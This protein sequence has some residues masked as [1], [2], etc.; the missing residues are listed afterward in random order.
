MTPASNQN[1]VDPSGFLLPGDPFVPSN[2]EQRSYKS[3]TLYDATSFAGA[4][5]N[6]QES[7]CWVQGLLPQGYSLR[8]PTDFEE[9]FEPEELLSE[10]EF[11]M[12]AGTLER[13]LSLPL[14]ER[15][16]EAILA[17]IRECQSLFDHTLSLSQRLRMRLMAACR[18]ELRVLRKELH[19]VR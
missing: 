13:S 18:A 4:L 5:L 10:L 7:F 11:E 8:E 9:F 12:E 6:K 19:G 2:Q 16:I 17:T 15:Q 14:S 3:V 1:H